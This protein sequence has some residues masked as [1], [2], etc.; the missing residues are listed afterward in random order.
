MKRKIDILM[1]RYQQTVR[2]AALAA[3]AFVKIRDGGSKAEILKDLQDLLESLY[4]DQ[5]R[6]EDKIEALMEGKK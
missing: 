2:N 6:L 4:G 5:K 1:E 3:G